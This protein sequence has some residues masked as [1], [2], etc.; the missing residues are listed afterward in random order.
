M[1]DQWRQEPK[2]DIA[3][4]N[5][6]NSVQAAIAF[7]FFSILAWVGALMP[8]ACHA[9]SFSVVLAGRIGIFYISPLSRGRLEFIQFR[10]RRSL[11]RRRPNIWWL[12]TSW[13]H[14]QLLSTTL[15]GNPTGAIELSTT[16]LLR[17][18]LPLEV[19]EIKDLCV[20]VH[21]TCSISPVFIVLCLVSWVSLIQQFASSFCLSMSSNQTVTTC[22]CS[23]LYLLRISFVQLP[24]RLFGMNSSFSLSLSTE[25]KH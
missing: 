8:C 6:R 3:G 17:R 10:L 25:S 15:H 13:R 7:A 23:C 16:D 19:T 18:I 11:S 21:L 12:P 1:A 9:L 14:R 5:G 4:W 22:T 24:L 2:K 20:C